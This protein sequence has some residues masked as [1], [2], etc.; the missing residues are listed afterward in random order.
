[1]HTEAQQILPQLLA[2]FNIA[3]PVLVGHSDGASIALIFAGSGFATQQLVLMAPHVIVEE[4]SLQGAREVKALYTAGGLRDRMAQHHHNA[5]ATFYGW[6][7]AW[8]SPDF[9]YWNIEPFLPSITSPMLV[10]QGAED[11]YGT[12]AQVDSI[13][14]AGGRT[15]SNADASRHRP[16]TAP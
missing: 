15:V 4:C 5:D 8:L 13:A 12:K 11:Q 1:M 7:D 6:N 14:T 16:R 3:K 10:V 9:R 2:H